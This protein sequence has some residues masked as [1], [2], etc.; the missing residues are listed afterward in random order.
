MYDEASHQTCAQSEE[1]WTAWSS[2]DSHRTRYQRSRFKPGIGCKGKM[3]RK[4]HPASSPIRICK[5]GYDC[6]QS[7]DTDIKTK[8]RAKVRKKAKSR[9]KARPKIRKK[10]EPETPAGHECTKHHCWTRTVPSSI[11][12]ISHTRTLVGWEDVGTFMEDEEAHT[13]LSRHSDE[14]EDYQAR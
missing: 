4:L 1:T 7:P 5:R 9:R 13:Q 14:D 6:D 3:S 10:N 11:C 8:N 12:L 2:E